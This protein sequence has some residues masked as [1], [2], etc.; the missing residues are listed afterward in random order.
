MDP[1]ASPDEPMLEAYTTLGFLA[2]STTHVQLGTMVTWATIRPPA[3]VV[4]LVTTLD[5]LSGGRAWLGVGIGY[6]ED[7]ATMTGLPFPSTTERYE[8]LEELLQLADRMWA[9]DRSPFDG[10]HH[11]LSE[12]IS[13]PRPI[14]RP[15]VLIGG[16]GERRT[17][18]LVARYAD[19]CNL[20]DV[21]D[22]GA[23]IARKLEVLERCCE[24]LGRDPKEIE[25]TLATRVAPGETPTQLAERCAT[26]AARGI[27][28]VVF[29][30]TGPWQR[31][32]DLDVILAAA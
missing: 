20:F 17:L 4:K 5:V 28:H 19:A 13:E 27:D 10:P 30:T 22:G 31:G 26:L 9:G 18:P 14:R 7:E 32:G 23:T 6:R 12:P 8:R 29:L 25:V 11:H 24:D 21:P 16:T 1:S 15:R 2:A 3:L